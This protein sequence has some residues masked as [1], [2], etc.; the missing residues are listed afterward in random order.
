MGGVPV[1]DITVLED[2]GETLADVQRR[3]APRFRRVEVRERVGRYL[4]GLLARIERK[5]GWQ[6]AE[7]MGEADPHGTQ[8]LLNEATWD[9]EAVRDDLRAY[10]AEHLGDAARGGLI[11]DETGV[12]Q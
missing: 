9:A 5:T 3:S 1:D 4:A 2:W 8:R 11:A 10:V 7:T 6:L 12:I